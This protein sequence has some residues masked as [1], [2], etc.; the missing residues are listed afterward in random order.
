MS[1]ERPHWLTWL[2]LGPIF[3]YQRFISKLLHRLIPGS[4]CRFHPSCSHYSVTA[5]T[6]FGLF[7]GTWLTIKR[8]IRCHPW[9]GQGIDEV[10]NK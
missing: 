5:Y 4:G 2:A 6:R 9:G 1:R 7:K 3:F 10:P 8:L